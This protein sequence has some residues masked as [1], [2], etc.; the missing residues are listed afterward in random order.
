MLA[1]RTRACIRAGERRS[2]RPASAAPIPRVRHSPSRAAAHLASSSRG[3]HQASLQALL[4]RDCDRAYRRIL[5]QRLRVLGIRDRPIS[6][7]SPWQNGCDE[8]SVEGTVMDEWQ[9]LTLAGLLF[10]GAGFCYSLSKVLW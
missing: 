5:I 3:C 7:R 10:I 4:I 8:G 6:P 1:N 9:W 2:S